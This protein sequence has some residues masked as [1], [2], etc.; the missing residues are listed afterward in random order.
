MLLSIIIPVYN[1]EKYIQKTLDSI[2][3][4]SFPMEEV[5]VIVVNDGTPDNSMQI[6]EEFEK[7][8]SNLSVIEQENK[9]LS[10]AR[11][12]G[13]SVAHGDYVWFVDSDDWIDDDSLNKILSILANTKEDVLV[14]KIREYDEMGRV[15]LERKHP[16]NTSD[17]C[18][19]KQCLLNS[20]FEGTPIQM[21][22]INRSFIF[23]NHL[24]FVEGILHEDIEILPRIMINAKRVVFEDIVS[25]CYLRR[26]SGNITSDQTLTHK[27]L[28]SLKYIQGEFERQLNIAQEKI[29]KIIYLK[30]QADIILN[31]YFRVPN[32]MFANNA[33]G[34]R[35]KK[36][37]RHCK[38][39]VL[40][41][42]LHERNIHHILRHALFLLSV[43]YY[44]KTMV[45]LFMK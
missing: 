24:Y 42:M 4:Q 30:E 33:E 6:V 44:H 35:E 2:Y 18:S 20:R 13:V 9:G 21:F 14:F 16:Y 43:N 39:C 37:L 5:E 3:N 29:T 23:T 10:G 1:V 25:Y 45:K 15:L 7:K 28:I 34:I 27:R 8:Y 22:I 41:S 40:R 38:K 32:E 11:N 26:S 12:T 31:I 19:G 17:I 36:Y